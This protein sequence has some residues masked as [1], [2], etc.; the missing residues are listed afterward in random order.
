MYNRHMKHYIV[1]KP[2]TMSG[3]PCIVGT[4][5]PMA[6]IIFLLKEGYTV[7]VIQQEYPHV[8]L[9]IL[10]GALDELI[11]QLAERYATP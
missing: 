6:R 11:E 1:S 9:D 4:R 3:A 2:G 7:E 10:Q 8:P 5:I